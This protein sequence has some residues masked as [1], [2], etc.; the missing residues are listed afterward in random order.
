MDRYWLCS[1]LLSG[2]SI[3]RDWRGGYKCVC[4]SLTVRDAEM[5]MSLY[6]FYSSLFFLF[7]FTIIVITIFWTFIISLVLLWTVYWSAKKVFSATTCNK[8]SVP[9]FS[10]HFLKTMAVVIS[11]HFQEKDLLFHFGTKTTMKSCQIAELTPSFNKS[12]QMKKRLREI[13]LYPILQ[14][15]CCH[16]QARFIREYRNY[17][18]LSKVLTNLSNLRIWLFVVNFV[19]KKF[20]NPIW[21]LDIS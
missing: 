5:R 17:H 8:E 16:C 7:L 19:N 18:Y 9:C 3:A 1:G 11:N 10:D 2:I 15:K 13:M 21:D 20:T 14:K 4:V 12:V 6:I